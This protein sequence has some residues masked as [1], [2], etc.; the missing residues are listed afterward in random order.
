MP[1]FAAP[2][3]AG[4]ARVAVVEE[5]PLAPLTGEAATGASGTVRGLAAGT[6]PTPGGTTPFLAS[7]DLSR[8]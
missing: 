6:A 2:R 3:L 8:L 5:A 4:V 7:L 1:F